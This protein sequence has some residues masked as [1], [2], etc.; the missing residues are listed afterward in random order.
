MDNQEN[1]QSPLEGTK[2]VA[3]RWE[4]ELVKKLATASLLEQRRARRWGIFF[5]ILGFSY[6]FLLIV[7]WFPDKFN[8]FEWE[9]VKS[10][11]HTA[12]VQ[13]NGVITADTEASADKVV[14]GLRNAFKDNKTK[15]VVLRLNTPGGSAVQS[16][17]IYDEIMR[18]KKKHED[19][20]VYAVVT[21]ICA[22]GGYYIASAADKIY[23]D[24]ASIVGSIGVIMGS[25]GFVD[26]ME[27]LG[28]ERRLMTAGEHKAIMDPFSPIKDG[29]REHI[30]TMLDE[31]HQ[32]FIT[33][34]KEGRGDRLKDN[35]QIFSGLFWSG[36]TSVELGL[37]DGL[38]SSSYVA[39]EI[40]GEEKLIDFTPTEDLVERLAKRFGAGMASAINQSWNLNNGSGV[41]MR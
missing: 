13:V 31:I 38:G 8:L 1:S 41:D 5:K 32:Q 35:G 19:I 12:L 2:Q 3:N 17:Y 27:K 9:S 20:P 26:S 24:K 34:V 25:F 10:E 14:T 4:K 18:L 6:L 21:D 37:A 7:L 33:A 29:E 40:V 36:E 11:N 28:V 22:S 16:G 30:Q 39:R 23:V 15:G